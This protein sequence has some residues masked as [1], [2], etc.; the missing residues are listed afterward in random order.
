MSGPVFD[1]PA[2]RR[3]TALNMP[4]RTADLPG[5][6]KVVFQIQPDA[7]ARKELAAQMGIIRIKKLDFS[8]EMTPD[9][10]HDWLLNAKLGATVVQEC[11][12][13]TDPVTTRIE[14]ETFRRFVRQLPQ[15]EEAEAE[16]PEDDSLEQ[17]GAY[18]DPGDVMAEA[19][20]L[21]L[22][23]YPRASDASLEGVDGL[24]QGPLEDERPNPFAALKDM[25]GGNSGDS[26][27][28]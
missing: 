5:R 20:A 3:S 2:P 25:M 10:H 27:P 4:L 11:V 16:M 6:G 12:V 8:G 19:L 14:T 18:V 24:S 9:G 22:P 7:E 28:S 26:D 15:I 17:L 13:T 23:D 1:S 21:A